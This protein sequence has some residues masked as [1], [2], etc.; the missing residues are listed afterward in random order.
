MWRVNAKTRDLLVDDEVNPIALSRRVLLRLINE[1]P[2]RIVKLPLTL[3]GNAASTGKM[4][5]NLI[6]T[7][8]NLIDLHADKLLQWKIGWNAIH[9]PTK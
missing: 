9:R 8:C 4:K 7:Q 6:L 1:N 2:G 3:D 5:L